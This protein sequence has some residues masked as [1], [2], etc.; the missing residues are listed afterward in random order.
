[1]AKKEKKFKDELKALCQESTSLMMKAIYWKRKADKA[2]SEMKKEQEV[3]R[4]R[5]LG[6]EYEKYLDKSGDCLRASKKIDRLIM[7][8]IKEFKRRSAIDALLKKT[9][10]RKKQG[11]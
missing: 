9:G 5:A 11:K 2:L 8:K 10:P 3:P 4:I 1:M 6:A 7:R